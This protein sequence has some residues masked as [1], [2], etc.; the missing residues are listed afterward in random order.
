[1]FERLGLYFKI[2]FRSVRKDKVYS[3]INIIGLTAAMACCFLLVFWIRYECTYEED[4]PNADRIY[5][6]IDM[7][8]NVDG[9]S[10][11][12]TSS[13]WI[14]DELKAKYPFV[15]QVTLVSIYKD[16]YFTEH[17][18]RI[19]L[20]TAKASP[21]FFQVFPLRCVAGTLWV[22][23]HPNPVYITEEVAIRY[24]GSAV[25]AVGKD[26][27]DFGSKE[28]NLR[29][30]IVGVVS[31]PEHSH[32]RFDIL[33]MRAPGRGIF[34]LSGGRC[35]VLA[36]DGYKQIPDTLHQ[37]EN[38]D[39][40][41]QSSQYTRPPARHAYLL[42]PFNDIHLHTDA[43]TVRL[44]QGK[45]SHYGDYKQVRMFGGIAC[46]ILLLAII[47]YVNMST[48]RAVNRN[49]EVGVRKVAGARRD[50]LIVRFL[51]ESFLLSVIAVVL[52]IDMAKLLHRAFEGVMGNRFLLPLNLETLGIATC[53]C[54]GT[55]LLAGGYSAFY[56]S[57]FHP[58]AALKGGTRTGS[59]EGLRKWLMGLQ[60]AL[61]IAVL[62][63][64]AVIYRQLDYILNKDL[65]FERD[66]AYE[67][68]TSLWYQ[69]EEYQQALSKNPYVINSTMATA[70]PFNVHMGYSGISWNGCD[71]AVKE[72]PIAMLTCD[73]RFASTFGLQMV[74]GEFLRPWE[75]WYD[76]ETKEWQSIVVNETFARQLK[77]DNPVGTIVRYSTWGDSYFS[78]G[79]VIGVVRDFFF[80]P[81][82][83]E[84]IPLIIN[85]NPQATDRMYVRIQPEKKA[86]T[87]AYMEEQYNKIRVNQYG[88]NIPF[89]LTPLETIY[90]AL[91]YKEIR[92]GKLLAFFS[93][94][95]VI[96]SCMGIFG[97]ISFMLEKRTREIAL[98]K[99]NGAT[100]KDILA[101]F[102]RELAVLVGLAS[103]A[104]LPVA[105]ILMYRWMEQYAYR[106]SMG[107]WVFVLIPI[108]VWLVTVVT[109]ILQ[110]YHAARRNPVDA[111]R[112]E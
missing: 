16:S 19:Q 3:L 6:V 35:Y 56:L 91:Y 106:V 59:R 46:L 87:L 17:D 33:F 89:I 74:A 15:E 42:Q 78:D 112:R 60:F 26:I 108:G 107:W 58:V 18:K 104:A 85:F 88:E 94:F 81:L 22:K 41:S 101:L 102:L 38:K 76:D 1:M 64:T 51:I 92:L 90:E 68:S 71:E 65:G 62:V 57:A 103:L 79:K 31:I 34:Y 9:I 14:M 70:P 39:M 12:P 45:V 43:E 83:K 50:Q 99:I 63:C 23:N 84:M 49:K 10:K 105:W 24:F 37:I 55:A 28:Y 111:L 109:V 48:A 13:Y 86:E 67:L 93:V 30:T 40:T 54:I 100:V 72:M 21:E 36:K 11:K 95:S 5:Q 32:L 52:A 98:R 4:H 7:E 20:V 73:S 27:G 82:Q 97:M 2:S 110:V 29:N 80:K 25:D 75:G 77:L 53:L 8:E 96:L 66:H 69:S 44:D 61:S 47:N